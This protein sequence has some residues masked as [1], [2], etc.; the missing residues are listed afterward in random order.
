MNKKETQIIKTIKNYLI[1]GKN[2]KLKILLSNIWT[3]FKI[4]DQNNLMRNTHD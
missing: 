1:E 4:Q 2:I 3:I